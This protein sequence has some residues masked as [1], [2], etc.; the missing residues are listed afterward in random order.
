MSTNLF[1]QFDSVS[2]DNWVEKIKQ[3]LKGKPLSVLVSRPE[4][5]LEIK[6]YHH[7]A[8][9]PKS[10]SDHL[11]RN[12]KNNDWLIRQIYSASTSNKK[13]LD[14]LNNGINNIGIN[15]TKQND[16]DE[17]SKNV[18]FEHIQSDVQFK[19]LNDA[20]AAQVPANSIVAFDP[21]ALHAHKGKAGIKMG[22]FVEF[23]KNYK[24]Q[25]SVW[26]SGYIYGDAGGSTTQ[27]L[28]FTIAH[29]NEYLHALTEE[30]FSVKEILPKIT[31]ELSVNENYLVNI[32]KFRVIQNLCKLLLEGYDYKADDT[33]IRIYAKTA[34]RYLALNDNHNNPLRQTTQAMS[35]VIGGCHSLTITNRTTG[36]EKID[37]RFDRLARNTQLILKEE[38]YLDKVIDPAAGSYF[39]EHLSAELVTKSWDLFLATEN[40]GGLMTGLASNLIQDQIES[41]RSALIRSL[42]NGDK[43]FLGVNKHPNGTD[44]WIK[45]KAAVTKI[46]DF[47][48]LEAFYLE[49]YLHEKGNDE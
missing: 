7:S 21:I 41:N 22:D 20:L 14:D 27:E 26:V 42:N 43:T 11:I 37:N 33:E 35:A 2:Y 46:N 19:S 32:A 9:I 29:L 16:F 12:R 24:N 38:S 40:E 34:S 28:A 3:D 6:A 31:I 17:L 39:L 18:L 47:K 13:L 8:N 30:G 1:D 48:A 36:N 10:N 25:N 45:P 4:P 23:Y 5:D 44:E 15:W 49:N